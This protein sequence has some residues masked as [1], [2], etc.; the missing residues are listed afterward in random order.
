MKIATYNVENLFDL[1]RSGHEYKEYIPNSYSQWNKKN[2]TIKLH[3]IAKVIFDINADI[4][5]LQEIES[6]QALKDLR[7]ELK[8]KGLYY[9]YHKIANYKHTTIKVAILSK[10]PFVYTHEI[11]VKSSYRYRNILEAKFKI[12]N[13]ELY[14]LV[15]HWKS[16]SGPESMR[17]VSAKKVLKR[18]EELGLDKNIIVLGDFNSHYE[19]DILFKRKRKHNDTDGITGINHILATKEHTKVSTQTTLP[20]GEFY[21]LWYDTNEENRYSYIYRGKKE[22]LDNIL[23]SPSLVKSSGIHYKTNSI[24][25]HKDKY[26]FSGK[27]INRWKMSR[28]KPRVHKGKGYSDHLAVIAE[29]VV[30]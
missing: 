11:A 23:I 28:K 19:E 18:T 5:G 25:S 24:H 9:Q 29:F 13:N 10:I 26:L 3:N 16:K 7:F 30:N 21:N 22:A 4:I 2:Y 17:V 15:N 1:K 14:V 8:R 27:S 20:K 12:N 6:E